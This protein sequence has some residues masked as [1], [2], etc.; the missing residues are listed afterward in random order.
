MTIPQIDRLIEEGNSLKIIA[1]A[2][3]EIANLKLKKIR[4]AVVRNRLFFDDISK[5]YGIVKGLAI[6]K[7]VLVPKPKKA[8]HILITS[9]YRFYGNINLSLI[10]FFLESTGN[11][12]DVD[13]IILGKVG[14][15]FFQAAKTKIFH[16]EVLLKDDLPTSQELVN[17]VNLILEYNQVFVYYSKLKSLLV[18]KPTFTDL[19]ATL[20][21]H[22]TAKQES[23]AFIFEPE[24]SKI[25]AFFDSQILTL[26]LEQVFLESELSRTTSR[27]ISMDQAETEANKFIREHLK[28]KAHAERNLEN[29]KILENFASLYA[30]KKG[31]YTWKV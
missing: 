9:N 31:L 2:Y 27:F 13:K 23:I 10:N 6:K 8:L 4:S 24:L 30:S 26:L 19:K 15:D 5:V 3:S 14:I 1:Q 7:G 12:K 22:F 29:I 21:T 25:L 17:L 16:K 11:L 20:D 18:Q 28:L